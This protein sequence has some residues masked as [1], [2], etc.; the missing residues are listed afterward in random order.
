MAVEV[1]GDRALKRHMID[2][3]HGFP[4]VAGRPLA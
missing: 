1:L 4:F 2:P 3:G